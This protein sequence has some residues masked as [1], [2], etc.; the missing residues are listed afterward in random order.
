MSTVAYQPYHRFCHNI[1]FTRHS[2]NSVYL[3]TDYIQMERMALCRI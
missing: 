3:H 2:E 1:K